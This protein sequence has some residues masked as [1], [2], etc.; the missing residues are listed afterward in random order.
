M[1]I[2]YLALEFGSLTPLGEAIEIS[3]LP[4][5]MFPNL[6]SM[7]IS[8]FFVVVANLQYLDLFFPILFRLALYYCPLLIIIF[9]EIFFIWNKLLS[10]SLL[11][12][13]L[14][15]RCEPSGARFG[16]FWRDMGNLHKI[17]SDL[18]YNWLKDFEGFVLKYLL[19]SVQIFYLLLSVLIIFRLLII[20]LLFRQPW[21]KYFYCLYFIF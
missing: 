11:V 3:L 1:T 4:L 7:A 12:S 10:M 19:W 2:S 8:Y 16:T 21:L 9:R 5:K 14:R 17:M 13:M 6:T 18:S 15:Q 20:L